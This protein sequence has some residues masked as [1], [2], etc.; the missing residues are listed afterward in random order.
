MNIRIVCTAIA[1]VVFSALQ[2]WCSQ[3]DIVVYEG[4]RVYVRD[5]RS[6]EMPKGRGLVQITGIPETIMPQTLEVNFK[7]KDSLQVL[8]V[9]RDFDLLSEAVLLKHYVGKDV[10][11]VIPDGRDADARVQKTARLLSMVGGPVFRID[12]TVYVGPYESIR[13]PE[14]PEGLLSEPA[15]T[16]DVD[17]SAAASGQA[18]L[19]YMATG[20]GWSADYVLNVDEET[21]TATLTCWI[22]VRNT[23]GMDYQDVGLRV[24]AGDVNMQPTADFRAKSFRTAAMEAAPAAAPPTTSPAFEYY[25]YD[26]PR[27]MDLKNNSTKRLLLTKASKVPVTTKYSARWS[28]TSGNR[29]GELIKQP[30][31]VHLSFSNGKK[32]GLGTALPAGTVRIYGQA[33]GKGLFLGE[34]NV[35]RLPEDAE[36]KIRAGRS[37]DLSVERKLIK[38]ENVG[39]NVQR[40]EWEMELRNASKESKL[41]TLLESIPSEFTVDEHNMPFKKVDARTIGFDVQLPAGTTKKPVVLR[42][43]VTIRY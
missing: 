23:S 37:F 43:T 32:H 18:E 6:L 20:M 12:G 11:L 29:P 39:K 24:V 19:S 30:V 14:I 3:M 31:D 13:F 28:A 15:V 16:L 10:E 21:D 9:D 26:F 25:T 17:N 4:G 38:R 36:A 22:G 5:V 35:P 7:G 41:L 42:Y 27:R 33:G 8:S 1:I 40:V 34:D 2:A